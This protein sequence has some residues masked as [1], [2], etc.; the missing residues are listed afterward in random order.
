[1]EVHAGEGVLRFFQ[2]VADRTDI[3][4][5]MFIRSRRVTC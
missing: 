5:G 3:A 4:L 2:Y 1:M